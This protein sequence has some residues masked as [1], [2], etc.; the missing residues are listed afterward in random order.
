M[1][2]QYWLLGPLLIL[3]LAWVMRPK[4][5]GV[6]YPRQQLHQRRRKAQEID[7]GIWKDPQ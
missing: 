4:D 6:D 1:T 3:L 2:D 5:D 7:P